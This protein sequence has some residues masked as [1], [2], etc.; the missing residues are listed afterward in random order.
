MGELACMVNST[1]KSAFL[2]SLVVLIHYW[3]LAVLK[4]TVSWSAAHYTNLVDSGTLTL[5]I[6]TLLRIAKRMISDNLPMN[7]L[8]TLPG[9]TILC[10]FASTTRTNLIFLSDHPFVYSILYIF[11]SA[12][13]VVLIFYYLC[14]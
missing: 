12:T 10:M 11:L 3:I 14:P 1:Q 4:L 9:L 8:I 5:S 13:M 6:I 2:F 7:Y